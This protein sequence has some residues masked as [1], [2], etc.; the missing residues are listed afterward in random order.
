MTTQEDIA[1][2]QL[3]RST[4]IGPKNFRKLLTE[5]GT[6]IEAVRRV[7]KLAKEA[8]VKGFELLPRRL[9]ERELAEGLKTGAKPFFLGRA[10]YP[11]L[12][13]HAP[14]APPF[15]WTKGTS[16]LLQRRVLGMVG[17]RNASSLGTR[18]ARKLAGALGDA[19][20]VVAS[21]LARGIDCAA[22]DASLK[23]GT[24][25][26]QAGGLYTVYPPE[27][28]STYESIQRHGLLLSEQRFGT[29]P[30]A[31]HFPRRNHILAGLCEA[32]IVIE[33][34]TG[35]GSLI[36]ARA[37][38]DLGRDVMAVPGHPFDPRSSG[39]NALLKDG[40]I[41][42]RGADD[43]L[44]ALAQRTVATPE[45]GSG[46]EEVAHK[47]AYDI[48]RILGPT[49][50]PEDAV[51]RDSGL[52]THIANQQIASLELSGRIVRDSG[53]RIALA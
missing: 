25:A 44:D 37:A 27:A 47:T 20:F 6:A 29:Y 22:H 23:T 39:C 30:Q 41:L 52:P 10:D 36:T 38:L 17:A 42:V 13:Q 49:P 32:L 2:L 28:K 1:H 50:T 11:S 7:P 9:A 16:C 21:G 31:R 18:F 33:G 4:R 45:K 15:L 51:I 24:I 34:A 43:V 14:D 12:L 19:G 53:G 46:P 48:I 8:G 26:I 3:I 35:S 5:Y 40:A